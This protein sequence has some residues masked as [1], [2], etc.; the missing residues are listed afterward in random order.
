[1]GTALSEVAGRTCGC[2]KGHSSFA[3]CSVQVSTC[4]LW[5]LLLQL[6]LLPSER[7]FYEADV[8]YVLVDV[9]M[10]YVHHGHLWR[11]SMSL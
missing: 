10:S 5:L 11:Y 8:A 3:V 2:S 6:L 1:M 9:L 7:L 4:G